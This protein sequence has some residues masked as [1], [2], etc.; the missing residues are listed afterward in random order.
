MGANISPHVV[1]LALGES[2]HEALQLRPELSADAVQLEPGLAPI[3]AR[4]PLRAAL[5]HKKAPA[6]GNAAQWRVAR[7]AQ[8]RRAVQCGGVRWSRA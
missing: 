3:R 6:W 2:P 8:Q 7:K 1:R 4:I 5:V